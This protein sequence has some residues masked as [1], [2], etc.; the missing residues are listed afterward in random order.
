MV[1]RVKRWLSQGK[2]VRIMTARVCPNDLTGLDGAASQVKIIE[3]W[4]LSNLGKVLP[5]TATKDYQMLELWDDRAVHV[6][7]N[8]GRVGV[9]GIPLDG[10]FIC[11]KAGPEDRVGLP[12]TLLV[13]PMNGASGFAAYKKSTDYSEPGY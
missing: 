2:D 3:A 1:A 4:C 11:G 8:T 13:C 9:N 5:V 6:V 7:P 12:E 10:P